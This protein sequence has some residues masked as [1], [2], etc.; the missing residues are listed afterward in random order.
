M[1]SDKM[2]QELVKFL[3]GNLYKY[4]VARR[5]GEYCL[6]LPKKDY[7]KLLRDFTDQEILKAIKESNATTWT[8]CYIKHEEVEDPEGAVRWDKV[9][10]CLHR[11]REVGVYSDGLREY[12]LSITE[13]EDTKAHLLG[14]DSAVAMNKF[15]K[16]IKKKVPKHE[17]RVDTTGSWHDDLIKGKLKD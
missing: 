5:N 1:I 8:R 2:Q 11:V 3:D 7:K 14:Y 6:T 13:N 17:P 12:L 10:N 16:S 9:N 15:R 4:R